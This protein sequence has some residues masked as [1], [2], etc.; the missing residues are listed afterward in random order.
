[1]S[2]TD[3]DRE[4]SGWAVGGLIFAASALTLVGM[5]QAI[6]G[7]VAIANDD[8][9]VRAPHYTFHLNVTTWGW[10]HLILGIFIFIVGISLFNQRPWAAVAGIALAML[11]AIDNFFFLPYYPV[12]SLILIALDVWVIWALS[13][14]GVIGE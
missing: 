6:Q 10:I 9:F 1:M 14:P 3:Y 12:W 2:S 13:R 7:I 5:F 11:S 4:P 8:F